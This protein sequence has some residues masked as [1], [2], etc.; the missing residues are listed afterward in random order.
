[1]KLKVRIGDRRLEVF[2]Q[3]KWRPLRYYQG[4]GIPGA[5]ALKEA[6]ET[7]VLNWTGKRDPILAKSIEFEF[8]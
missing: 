3:G 1:M 5:K 4:N 7:F 8:D 2:F 6:K